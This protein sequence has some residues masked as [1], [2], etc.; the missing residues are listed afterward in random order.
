MLKKRTNMLKDFSIFCLRGQ[1][2]YQNERYRKT[3]IQM[4]LQE[5]LSDP[6][7]NAANCAEVNRTQWLR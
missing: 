3:L 6:K 2:K 7:W 1:N 5:F 4:L